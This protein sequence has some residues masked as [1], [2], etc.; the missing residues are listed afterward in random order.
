[1][2]KY[3]SVLNRICVHIRTYTSQNILRNTACFTIDH[4]TTALIVQL[5]ARVWLKTCFSCD[6]FGYRSRTMF[7]DQNEV[8]L[9]QKSPWN[10][11]CKKWN[12]VKNTPFFKTKFSGDFINQTPQ[13]RHFC[14]FKSLLMLP[15]SLGCA[16]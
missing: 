8:S 2:K 3:F 13:H 7:L 6:K 16:I 15:K 14:T 10:A 11:L 9:F 4:N 12:F 5:K 1:M